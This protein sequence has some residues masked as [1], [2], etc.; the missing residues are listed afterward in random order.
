MN[1]RFRAFGVALVTVLLANLSSAD[2]VHLKTGGRL[3]GAVVGESATSLTIEMGIGQ[4]SVPK[5]SVERVERTSSA[6]SEY[7]ARLAAVVPGDLRSLMELARFATEHNLRTEARLAWARILAIDPGNAEAHLALG[8]VLVGNVYVDEAEAYHSRGY[9]YYDG[10]WMT[11]AEQAYLLREREMKA[12]EERREREA[13]RA[14]REEE[15]RERRAEAAADRERERAR[16]DEHLG[17]GYPVWGYGGNNI[18]VGSPG[19][20]GYAAGCAGASC[21]AVPP[22]YVQ[23]PAVPVAPIPS[24]RAAPVHP[25]SIR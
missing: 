12:D 21:Y 3:E 15:D 9:I 6:Q 10:R 11:P 18:L 14:V 4:V 25:S 1:Q 17:P 23:R 20:G 16:A 24:P 19:W 7:R 8:H 5:N 22:M 2:V 13:R